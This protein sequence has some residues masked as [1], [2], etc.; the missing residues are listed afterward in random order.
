M[1]EAEEAMVAEAEG[2]TKAEEDKATEE[3]GRTRLAL[4]ASLSR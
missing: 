4:L 2:F 3:E 1:N